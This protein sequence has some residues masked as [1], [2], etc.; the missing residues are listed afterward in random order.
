MLLQVR[1]ALML[2]I[3]D[4][5]FHVTPCHLGERVTMS[6][7]ALEVKSVITVKC[8]ISAVNLCTTDIVFK[9]T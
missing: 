9:L 5:S 6:L 3:S 7:P 1:N 2:L 8:I 4:A